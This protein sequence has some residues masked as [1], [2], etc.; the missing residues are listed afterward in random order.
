MFRHMNIIFSGIR[1]MNALIKLVQ[2]FLEA[3]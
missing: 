2:A 3:F 1:F